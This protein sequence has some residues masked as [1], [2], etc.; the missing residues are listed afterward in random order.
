MKKLSLLC[1]ASILI[2]STAFAEKIGYVDSQRAVAE[3]S[4]TKSAQQ[5]IEAQAKKLENE[6]RQKDV[7]LQKEQLA[8]QKKG[9]KLTDKE[10][11]DFQNKVVAFQNFVNSSQESLSKLQYE[12]MK[13]IDE[14]LGKAV[15]KVA[16]DGKYDY[17]FEVGAIK[18]GGEDI[19]DK[20][21][22]EME[23]LK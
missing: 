3:F 21:K 7:A 6:M 11:T 9:D 10:K 23:A 12:K 22:K 1:V 19:T 5:T 15:N 13:K 14:V 17:V 20:V 8:L 2:A 18:F 4:L 16:K